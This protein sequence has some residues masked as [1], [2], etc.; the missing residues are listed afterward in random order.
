MQKFEQPPEAR[1]HLG[2]STL[3]VYERI[4]SLIISHRFSA[5]E[6]INQ[7]VL[8]RELN[9]SRTPVTHAL[10]KLETQGLVDHLPEKGFY[11]HQLSILELLDLF[12]LR[13]AID[14]IIAAEMVDSITDDQC[15]QLEGIF[16]S[17]FH[18]GQVREE[19]VPEY[20]EADSRFHRLLLD[21]STNKLAKRVDDH[22]QIFAR[23]FTAG[24]LR[25]PNETLQ[26][27]RQIIDALR[28]RDR[29]RAVDCVV[30]HCAG[31]KNYLREVVERLKALG[32]DPA[33]IPYN[34]LEES[35][36]A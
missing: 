15:E 25:Q 18:A 30:R 21:F 35:R 12:V 4:R 22:F 3:K 27:H 2:G 19:E 13:E 7:T 11:V 28:A 8:A 32:V 6:K 34:K 23:S 14:M 10:H 5:G 26:E 1:R 33:T 20:F 31:T 36:T 17:Y 9:V 29:K 24:L 16:R